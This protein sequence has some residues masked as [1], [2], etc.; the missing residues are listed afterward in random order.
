M[1]FKWETK[2]ERIIRG[3]RISTEKKL[4]G[5]RL[6]NELS[7]KVLSRRQLLIRKKLR[8]TS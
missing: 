5:I 7:D 1:I 3:A 8:E 2:K 6:M 4:E